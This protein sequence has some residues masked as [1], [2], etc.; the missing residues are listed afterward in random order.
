MGTGR[1]EG[2]V[3]NTKGEELAS[4]VFIIHGVSVTVKLQSFHSVY[5]LS[6]SGQADVVTRHC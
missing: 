4:I 5:K 6:T 1:I 2:R 3:R